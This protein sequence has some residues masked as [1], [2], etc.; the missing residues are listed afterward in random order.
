MSAV[1]GYKNG[2]EV[3]LD[4]V[5]FKEYDLP[6]ALTPSDD[7]MLITIPPI[8]E[9][10]PTDESSIQLTETTQTDCHVD[11]DANSSGGEGK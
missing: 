2:D 7:S 5:D 9:I 4:D 6:K 1:A 3:F 8:L 10:G 11:I